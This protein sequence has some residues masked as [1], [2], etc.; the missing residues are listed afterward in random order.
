MVK[1]KDLVKE[2]ILSFKKSISKE[3]KSGGSSVIGQLGF[4]RD[5][6]VS[7]SLFEKIFKVMS[8]AIQNSIVVV[9]EVIAKDA[10]RRYAKFKLTIE[11][12]R[13]ECSTNRGL[14]EKELIEVS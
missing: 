6:M 11:E 1:N 9:R 7:N 13:Q 2:R 14:G 4:P 10:T 8:S 12:V 3:N 5:E